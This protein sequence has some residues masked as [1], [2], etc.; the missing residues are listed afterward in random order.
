[1]MRRHWTL[2]AL[3]LALLTSS[4]PAE[5]PADDAPPAGP[6]V[7]KVIDGSVLL[8]ADGVDPEVDGTPF[9][10]HSPDPTPPP[11][12]CSFY[13]YGGG[14]LLQPTFQTD[15]AFV[16]TRANL[17]QQTDFT[18]SMNFAPLAGLGFTTKDCWG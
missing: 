16:R 18:R 8:P 7:E 10:L 12:K 1:P 2:A 3:A 11:P 15:P 14:Y 9:P 17:I 13:L 6:P 4:V 5:P